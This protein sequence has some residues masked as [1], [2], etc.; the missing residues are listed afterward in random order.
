MEY[1]KENIVHAVM[2]AFYYIECSD[3]MVGEICCNPSRMKQIV[4]AFFNEVEFDYIPEG[5]GR[6]RGAYLKYLPSSASNE[7]TFVTHSESY[8]LKMLLI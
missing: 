7:I 3:E 4:Q 6:F 8:R 1:S 2:S 5:I